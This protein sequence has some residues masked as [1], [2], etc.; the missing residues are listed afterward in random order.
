MEKE[1][2]RWKMKLLAFNTVGSDTQIAIELDGKQFYK[3]VAFSK[4]S[5]AFFPNLEEVLS[6]L[7]LKIADFDCVACVIGP[8]SFTGV[9]IGMSV[10]KSFSYS[11]KIP[12]ITMSSLELLAQN[13]T[14]D[15]PICAVIDAGSGLVYHQTFDE[16]KPLYN[17]RVD[18][19]PHLK[20][21]LHS[22][23]NDYLSFVY[24]QN[25]EHD[26]FSAEFGKTQNFTPQSLLSL[27]KL[28]FENKD[29][30]DA[31]TASPLY[32]RVSQAEQFLG[33]D[34]QFT[35]ATQ[36]DLEDILV[37]EGQ[38]DEWDL[39]WNEIG[40]K[41]SFDNPSYKCFLLR[42]AGLPKGM[43]SILNLGDEAEILRVVVENSVRLQG[44]ATKML[45]YLFD[46]L[47]KTG[48]KEV[49]LEVN[50]QNYPAMSLY[51]KLG[52]SEIGRRKEYYGRKEDAVT[53][54]KIL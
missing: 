44:V 43:V 39:Q 25:N 16:G 52:F 21:F 33:K 5:E 1:F 7:K 12:L 23:Y 32:L 17:P 47:R 40:I 45:S 35:Q 37:L 51:Q 11:L 2:L 19:L 6:N 46:W 30:A 3:E 36:E 22:N 13:I 31:V 27:A 15:R 49:F 26:D 14:S 18:T 29:F 4:H 28:K 9:R 48:C 10:A 24:N 34:L 8:G 41:Q 20:G 38:N 53:M 42:I 54:K 50:N